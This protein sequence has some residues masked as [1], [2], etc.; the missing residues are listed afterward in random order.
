E[1]P[2]PALRPPAP[3]GHNPGR[4]GAGR[5]VR[6]RRVCG[7]GGTRVA[8]GEPKGAGRRQDRARGAQRLGQV[9]A[10]QGGGGA[11]SGEGRR[12][13]GLRQP[14]RGVPPQGRVPAPA[15]R[16]RLAVPDQPPEARHHGPL[17]PP[18]LAQT[19][20][21]LG[22]RDRLAHHRRPRPLA[23]RRTPDRTTVRRP[24][25]ARP[26][27][28]GA[29]PG[30]GPAPLGRALKRRGRRHPRDHLGGSLRAATAGQDHGSRH[31]RSREP[32]LRVRRGALPERGPGG[33]AR[34]GRVRGPSGRTGGRVG[35]L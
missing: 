7:I 34:A 31:P 6:Q 16:D 1:R 29:G 19:P 17:R 13:T 25:T 26:P 11:V 18:R 30:G 14:R 33:R 15:R 21:P 35:R 28:P 10:A 32:R 5:E 23:A 8:G 22:P 2:F 24:T 27:R 12:D 20:G 4:P 3:R 9:H